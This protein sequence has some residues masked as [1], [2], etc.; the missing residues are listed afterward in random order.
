MV[1]RYGY[2]FPIGA[3]GPFGDDLMGEWMDFESARRTLLRHRRDFFRMR[4]VRGFEFWCDWHA[5][6]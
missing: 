2:S 5:S 3:T 4:Y 6:R 1:L